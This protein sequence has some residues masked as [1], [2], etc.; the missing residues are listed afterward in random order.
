MKK[1]FCL[2]AIL[3]FITTMNTFGTVIIG[4]TGKKTFL[5]YKNL[6][7]LFANGEL[8]EIDCDEKVLVKNSLT[9]KDILS[10]KDIN[11][12]EKEES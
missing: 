1:I 4:G 6:I 9:L 8:G 7:N 11:E 2:L 3:L 10:F 5:P 12:A